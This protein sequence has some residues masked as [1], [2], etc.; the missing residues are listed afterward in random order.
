MLWTDGLLSRKEET[1]LSETIRREETG[2]GYRFKVA[3]RI[4]QGRPDITSIEFHVR[5]DGLKSAHPRPGVAVYVMSTGGRWGKSSE[6]RY[7][8]TTEAGQ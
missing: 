8:V 6:V 7:P 3:Q 2:K 5:G 1:M 4:F